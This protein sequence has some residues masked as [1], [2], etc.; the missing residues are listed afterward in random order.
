MVNLSKIV[1]QLN[2][3]RERVERQLAGLNAAIT[4]FANVYGGKAKPRPTMS[5]AG[6][7]SISLAQ[8]ARWAKRAASGAKPKR[9]MSAKA[10][11]KIAAAQRARWAKVKKAKR[12]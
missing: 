9:T 1:K 4:A 10:R 8:K 5:A 2:K 6:R 11:A 12:A 3:E 7:Q